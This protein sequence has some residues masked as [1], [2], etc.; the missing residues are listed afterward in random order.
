VA[1][2]LACAAF[3]LDQDRAAAR[4]SIQGGSGSEGPSD[5]RD[6]D[7]SEPPGQPELEFSMEYASAYVFRGYNVFQVEHQ[8]EQ[9]WVQR[10]RFIWA[11]PGTNLSIG[12]AA[13]NQLTG[14]NLV[15]NVAAGVGAEQALFAEYDFTPKARLGLSTEL[16]VIAFPWANPNVAETTVPLFVSISTE[17]RYLHSLY[18]YAGYLR[19]V[20]QG[21]FGEDHL[22]LNPSVEKRFDLGPRFELELQVGAGIKVF[23]LDVGMIR[24]NMFDVL[25]NATLYYALSDILYVA[26]KLGWAWTNL[27]PGGNL[28]ANQRMRHGFSDEY[29]PFWAVIVGAEFAPRPS[30]KPTA[31]GRRGHTM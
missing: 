19:G 3:T 26:A 28:E 27:T 17:L 13:A 5:S 22:Y 31:P 23:Q 2:A 7:E 9:R 15:D 25:A 10:P 18:L 11:P 1:L 4:E 21:P 20:R 30:A 14:D 24:D 29:V 16:A 6:A 8:N 12:Y